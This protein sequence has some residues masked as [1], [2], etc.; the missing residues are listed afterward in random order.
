MVPTDWYSKICSFNCHFVFCLLECYTQLIGLVLLSLALLISMCLNVIFCIRQ[1]TNLCKGMKICKV[2]LY[3]LLF[4]FLKSSPF[5]SNRFQAGHGAL[6]KFLNILFIQTQMTAALHTILK[7][8]GMFFNEFL[9]V[10]QPIT[11]SRNT[12]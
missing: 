1:R 7:E 3:S 6:N 11:I 10:H 2:K 4:Y 8:K 12:S 5:I 9:R